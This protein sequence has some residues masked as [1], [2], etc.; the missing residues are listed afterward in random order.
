MKNSNCS[1]DFNSR[2]SLLVFFS[3]LLQNFAAGPAQDYDNPKVKPSS[4][5]NAI[6][7]LAVRY[8]KDEDSS[9][10]TDTPG[11]CVW[12]GFVLRPSPVLRPGTAEEARDSEEESEYM[13]PSSRP[14]LPP[15]TAPAVGELPA[16]PRHSQPLSLLTAQTQSTASSLSSRYFPTSR[17]EPASA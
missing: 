1:T 6:Y 8:V 11:L 9:Q 13:V 5:A 17:Y 3:F 16:V 4:S 12:G 14:I 10:N 2:P 7:S 15:I